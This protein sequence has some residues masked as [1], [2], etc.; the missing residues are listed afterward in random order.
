MKWIFFLALAFEASAAGFKYMRTTTHPPKYRSNARREVIRFGPLKLV[1]KDVCFTGA[2]NYQAIAN[3]T[4]ERKPKTG[5]PSMDLKGQAGKLNLS[6]GIPK[7]STILASRWTWVY[8]DGTE[9]GPENDV[10]LHHLISSDVTKR[11]INPFSG[12]NA[13]D[14]LVGSQFNNRGQDTGDRETLYTLEDSNLISGYHLGTLPV[15]RVQYDLI[16]YSS[17][18]KTLY[19]ELTVEYLRGRRGVDTGT[20]LESIGG[21]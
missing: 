1:G 10:Y 4:Q 17:H 5:S 18:T 19:L 15:I 7:N 13:F 12:C 16:N 20:V 3:T 14:E 21:K 2:G 9:A 6:E 8:E 11:K